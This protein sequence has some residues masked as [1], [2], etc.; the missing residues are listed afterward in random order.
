MTSDTLLLACALLLGPLVGAAGVVAYTR[1]DRAHQR[2]LD[3]F[4]GMLRMR[5][6]WLSPEWVGG[7]NLAPV[8]FARF[9]EVLA[10]VETLLAR[11]TDPAWQNPEADLRRRAVLETENAACDLLLRMAEAL[12]VPMLG[13]DLRTRPVAPFGWITDDV[14]NRQTRELLQQVLSGARTIRIDASPPQPAPR[15]Y[16]WTE[17]ARPNGHHP[18]I[19]PSR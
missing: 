16:G 19:M 5:R 18:E 13:A 4:H 17:P 15:P 9:P 10:A 1:W 8:E 14:Q 2:R 6:V 3:I 11:Y 7:L 12:K